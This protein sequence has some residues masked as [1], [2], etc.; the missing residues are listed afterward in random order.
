MH[1]ASA[2][3]NPD[4]PITHHWFD[5]THITYGVLTTGVAN[6]KWQLE[7]SLFR[8]REPDERRWN[9][10]TP[11]LDSYSARLSW[12]PE[13]RWSTELSFGHLKSPEARE[14]LID[15]ERYIA[16]ASYALPE[17]LNMSA[18]IAVKRKLPGR[19]ST[20]LFLEGSYQFSARETVFSRLESVDNDELFNATP[21]DPRFGVAY[22]VNKF[23]LGYGYTLPLTGPLSATF[24][25]SASVYAKPAALDSAYGKFPVSGTFFVK[26][27]LGG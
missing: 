10:E 8:G 9:I 21:L 5:S 16:S 18:G 1:R 22:R 3:I 23:T 20:A 14:P 24:G 17:G 11:K 2:K 7:A 13:P 25:G 19:T 26:F 6:H 4:A 12:N 15:E 27:S